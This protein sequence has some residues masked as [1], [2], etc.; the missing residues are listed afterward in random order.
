MLGADRIGFHIPGYVNNFL[1]SVHELTKHEVDFDTGVVRL[2]DRT[3]QVGAWP[4]SVD[5]RSIENE[6]ARAIK[7]GKT[8][9]IRKKMS[10]DKLIISIDRLDY[11]KGIPERLYAIDRFFLKRPGFRGKVSFLIVTA[12][13]RSHVG[14]YI[15]LK[16]RI[17]G[18]VGEINGKYSQLG[19]TPIHYFYKGLS[20]KDVLNLYLA[21]DIALI[22]P[23]IDGMNL[24]AK[25]YVAAQIDNTGILILSERTGAAK[26]LKE[27]I[28]VNPYD[29]EN[30]VDA[31]TESLRMSKRE[32]RKRMTALR[33]RVKAWDIHS[34]SSAFLSGQ[35]ATFDT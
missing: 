11:T 16:K 1:E 19:W 13:S 20:F 5:F 34:W 18:I 33:N 15:D 27:A 22:T 17:D 29:V 25:E 3:V 35:A 32:E 8:Q 4:V 23:L 10:A 31:I 21:S 7:S 14:S 24:V 6:A 28:Q 30:V 26:E 9:T 12:P 2:K